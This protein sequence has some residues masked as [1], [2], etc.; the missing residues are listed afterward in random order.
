LYIPAFLVSLILQESKL[1][2]CEQFIPYFMA[3][4]SHY[5]RYII[6]YFP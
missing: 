5:E 4:K 2:D 6:I 3:S 1:L